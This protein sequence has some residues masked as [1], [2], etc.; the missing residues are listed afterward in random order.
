MR[1]KRGVRG[2]AATPPNRRA[3]ARVC[4][5]RD[6]ITETFVF[7]S[8]S[9]SIVTEVQCGPVGSLGSNRCADFGSVGVLG[10]HGSVMDVAWF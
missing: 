10:A 5:E 2:W 9:T 6:R 7:F 8:Q 1:W 4:S 3:A